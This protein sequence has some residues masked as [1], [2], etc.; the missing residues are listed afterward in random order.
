[1]SISQILNRN[2]I[3]EKLCS[4]VQGLGFHF[5]AISLVSTEHNTI[6]AVY[7]TGIFEEIAGR[8]KHFLADEQAL[9]DIQ[10]DIVKTG[11]TEVIAGK[12]KRFDRWIFEEF[13]HEQLI[14]VFA[15]LVICR[16]RHGQ[17]IDDWLPHGQWAEQKPHTKHHN[18][19]HRI[20][21]LILDP[22]FIHERIVIGTVEAGFCGRDNLINDTMVFSLNHLLA[23]NALPIWKTKLLSL[24]E[25]VT[26]EA[27]ESLNADAAS[28]HYL[29][30]TKER[31]YV[32]KAYSSGKGYSLLK[33]CQPRDDGI[34]R[35]AI[36]LGM[37][38]F[39]PPIDSQ[40]GFDHHNPTAFQLGF[41]FIAAFPL[42]FVL[43][44]FFSDQAEEDGIPRHE[45]VLYIGFQK[46]HPFTGIEGKAERFARRAS[47]TIQQVL[48]YKHYQERNSQLTTLH[49]ITK[50][51]ADVS[52]ENAL[53]KRIT[54]DG[55]NILAADIVTLY[56]YDQADNKFK[57]DPIIAGRIRG[58]DFPTTI[59]N[60]DQIP[61]WLVH[62]KD[63]VYLTSIE[64]NSKF[65]SSFF[66]QA[67][68]IIS[69]AGIQLRAGDEIV[70][71]M[72]INYR[73]LHDFSLHKEIIET[74]ASSAAIAIKNHRWLNAIRHSERIAITSSNQDELFN[75]ILKQAVILTTAESGTL[76]LRDPN[77]RKLKLQ[78]KASYLSS[79]ATIMLTDSLKQKTV[80]GIE[81]KVAEEKRSTVEDIDACA[82]LCVPLLDSENISQGV[83]TLQ[84]SSIRS[85]QSKQLLIDALGFLAVIGLQNLEL[86]EKLVHEKEVRMRGVMSLEVVHQM[87][88]TIGAIK[89]RAWSIL[90]MLSSQEIALAMEEAEYIVRSSD[91]LLKSAKRMKDMTSEEKTN[92]RLDDVIQELVGRLILPT[93]ITLSVVLHDCLFVYAG[94]DQLRIIF[95]NLIDNAV[96][97]MISGGVL[98]IDG[99]VENDSE[100]SPMICVK[101]KD[102]GEGIED[103][104]I[105][106]IFRDGF[107]TKAGTGKGTGLWITKYTVEYLGGEINVHS[108][109]SKGTE[110]VLK[111]PTAR[112]IY[113]NQNG[114]EKE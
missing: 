108:G 53:L 49:Y 58:K 80:E 83:L 5:A 98:T 39:S 57:P 59:S 112:T 55:M 73:R 1:M 68:N 64:F 71:V 77:S 72:F 82:I 109:T 74:L 67:E 50:A 10:A 110:F 8:A 47:E 104:H 107:T 99:S 86:K 90:D 100:Q 35:K 52:D 65:R 79:K 84:S 19:N 95:K 46:D 70:G 12:D 14:R 4:D 51:L 44:G 61:A 26:Q 89:T 28:I 9:R 114:E 30:K 69:V 38:Q 2:Q 94:R 78:P 34:G 106:K 48:I 23:H 96:D 93:N 11:L 20:F 85:F 36:E 111:F 33:C 60:D 17:L 97:A 31:K 41:K 75:T 76:K 88:N 18:N 3:F 101:V 21:E 62:Q 16:D 87:N 43:D 92:L 13:N 54:W 15:P 27:V 40:H 24:L 105:E 81:G 91:S 56:E 7:G 113:I 42:K 32:Y 37:A 45:G 66:A 25:E 63:N 102:T 103:Q 29:Y 22:E 6:E